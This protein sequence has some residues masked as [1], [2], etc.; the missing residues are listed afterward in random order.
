MII[1]V[2]THYISE[3]MAEGLRQRKETPFIEQ[4]ENGK[5]RF[6]MPVGTIMLDEAFY[7]MESRLSFMEDNGVEHQIL[8]FPGLF[9]VD[10]LQVDECISLLQAFNN[11][12]AKLCKNNPDQFSGL[13]AL[14]LADM[15]LAAKEYRRA[16][17][18]LGLIGAILPIN[19][20]ISLAHANRM[21]PLFELAEKI[22]GH[23]F[24]HPGPRP[25][26]T[27]PPGSP[28]PIPPFAD[29]S[30]A[31]QALSVQDRCAACMVTLLFSDFLEPYKKI[32]PHVANLGGTLPMVIERIDQ[33]N[34]TR[35][36][37]QPAPSSKLGG[38]Y[39]D[40]S[41]L[42]PK[43]IEIAASF[44]G[45]DKIL[46]GTDCPIFLTQWSKDA[47]RHSGL[48]EEGQ[49]AVFEGNAKKIL[50]NNF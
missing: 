8:S 49:H 33:V 29:N 5:E 26:E 21:T 41:S 22:G 6:H 50:Q 2:H 30:A 14:P 28:R 13:A 4:L 3:S 34:L 10:S 15:D 46:F 9:G 11:E 16:R 36:P 40:C 23:L 17:L 25:D 31:R 12:T 39:V 45:T 32:I 38:V 47:V 43:S 1:D 18:E 35:T 42:G 24:I 48:D 20:F 44:Y 19:G 37:D 7:N 27:P